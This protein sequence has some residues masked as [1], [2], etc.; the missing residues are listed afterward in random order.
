MRIGVGINLARVGVLGGDFGV[1]L[2]PGGLGVQAAAYLGGIEPYH[3][4]D[5]INNRALY[6]GADVGTVAGGTGYSFT[7]ASTGYYQNADGTLTLFG[8]NLLTHSEQFDNAAWQKNDATVTANAVVAPTGTTTADQI[9]LSASELSRVQQPLTGA[10]NGSYTFTV[11]LRVASGSLSI[12]FGTAIDIDAITVTAAWQ[13]FTVTKTVTGVDQPN[14]TI[15]NEA[16]GGA[17]TLYAWGAQID[18]AAQ[19][20]AYVPTTSAAAGALRRGDRGVLIEGSRTNLLTYSQQFDDAAWGKTRSSITANATTAPDGTLTADKLVE[21]TDNNTHFVLNNSAV[22]VTS[23][24][25]AVYSVFL[26]AGERTIAQVLDN[27]VT[28]ATFDLSSGVATDV[29]AGVTATITALANGWYRCAMVRNAGSVNGRIVVR[30]VSTGTTS[31]YTGDGTSGIFIWGAQLEAASFPSSYIPTVAA[32]ATRAADSLSISDA[33]SA[34]FTMFAEFEPV[35]TANQNDIIVYDTLTNGS[36]I[37]LT[38]TP[39]AWV[40]ESSVTTAIATGGSAAVVGSVS[41]VAARFAVNDTLLCN[42]GTLGSAD[43]SN[44]PPSTTV[45][46]FAPSVFGG[47]Q[48]VYLRRVAIIASGATNAQLQAMTT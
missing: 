5:F 3:Y 32:S 21:N 48:S 14:L 15:R 47:V 44:S 33:R 12:R 30:L 25:P 6:A 9:N 31:S 28:G 45:L 11:W 23:G 37:Y 7:R 1:S 24:A 29:P 22:T 41:R 4:L 26:K 43:T 39:A 38:P 40:R 36:G 42:A 35:G 46:K 17:K 27:D 18:Q 19:A 13:R 16:G 8:Y 34:P 2:G 10:P 20:T